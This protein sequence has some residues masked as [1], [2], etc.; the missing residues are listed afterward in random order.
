[1]F[2]LFCGP[3][4]ITVQQLQVDDRGI[5]WLNTEDTMIAMRAVNRTLT[6]TEEHYIKRVCLYSWKSLCHLGFVQNKVL[7]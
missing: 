4:K 3:L 1:M 5:G 6:D 7:L 2:R